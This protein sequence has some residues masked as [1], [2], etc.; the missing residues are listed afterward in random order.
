MA[1]RSDVP[2]TRRGIVA[3]LCALG[4]ERGDTLLVHASLGAIGWVA[5]GARTVVSA[6]REAVGGTGNI[7]VATSTESN[8]RTSRVHR[9]KLVRMDPA[10]ARAYL[11]SLPAFDPAVTPG[12]T[13]AIAEAVRT[14]DGAVRSAHPQ[15]SFAA[16]GPDAEYLMADHVLYCHL[17][18]DS[19]L[20][21]LCKLD[22]ARVLLLGV[23]YQA[24]SALHLAEYRY[25][26]DPPLRGYQCV[27]A[28]ADGRRW[29]R[30]DDV[31]LDDRQFPAIGECVDAEVVPRRGNVGEAECRLFSLSA[32]V[33]CATRWMRKHRR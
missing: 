21:K 14:R 30:Y 10:Q 15:S 19:P 29:V 18:E 3:D 6:L 26:P 23:G 24:C 7:V 8:S 28:T 13:G 11:E 32:A 4:V 12:E 31:V 2:V 27:A 20:G 17:G 16:V 22:T 33:D 9:S 1:P 5:G 25:T